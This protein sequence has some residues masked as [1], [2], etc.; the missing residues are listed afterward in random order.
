MSYS[1]TNN[2]IKKLYKNCG[3]KT[4]SRPFGVSK[5]LTTT[6]LENDIFEAIYLYET[7]S[8]KAIEIRPNQHARLLSFFLQ[9]FFS[10][11]TWYQFPGPIF[12]MFFDK[13]IYFAMLLHKLAKFHYHAV[14]FPS[15]SIKFVFRAQAFD[16]VMTFEYL[17]VQNL[18]I[19]TTKRACEVKYKTFFLVLLA[20]S[21]RHTKQS[22]K[23]A[24]D[25]TFKAY[26]VM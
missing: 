8:S 15:F 19:S 4:S 1:K 10:S 20:L 14:Y 11:R 23:I 13:N 22:S 7:C 21:F 5:E 17:K 9:R 16:D 3:L 2:F 6:L 18:M 24:V 12:Q 25:T 26:A